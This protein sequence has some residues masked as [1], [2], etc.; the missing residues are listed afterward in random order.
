MGAGLKGPSTRLSGAGGRRRHPAGPG[1]AI[2]SLSC[3][4]DCAQDCA[5]EHLDSGQNHPTPTNKAMKTIN[6]DSSRLLKDKHNS[7][8]QMVSKLLKVNRLQKVKI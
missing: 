6:K 8:L 3:N 1:L 7:K 2:S 4:G 5:R